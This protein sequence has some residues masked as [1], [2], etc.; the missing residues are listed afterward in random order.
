[1]KRIHITLLG[2]IIAFGLGCAVSSNDKELIA[3]SDYKLWQRVDP[4][5]EERGTR[6]YYFF[7]AKGNY[8][9]FKK[10]KNQDKIVPYEMGDVL[11]IEEWKTLGRDSV[12]IGGMD[13]KIELLNDTAF[14]FSDSEKQL[15]ML[16]Y[17]N[18][19]L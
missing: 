12:S 4:Q 14:S 17:K 16:I 15:T 3:G 1:M 7:D 10:Y 18:D 6:T 11:L 2:L 9:L 19:K 8:K 5:S 13:Y